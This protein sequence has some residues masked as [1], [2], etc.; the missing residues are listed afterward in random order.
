MNRAFSVLATSRD[1]P[2]DHWQ[3]HNY[4]YVNDTSLSCLS[5]FTSTSTSQ[6]YT[7]SFSLSLSLSISLS[8]HPHVCQYW[9]CRPSLGQRIKVGV[10]SYTAGQVIG[11]SAYVLQT[12][13][14]VKGPALSAGAFMGVILCVGTLI[15]SH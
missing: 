4:G 6:N 7:L 12:G 15:R 10:F 11:T 1:D 3:D 9:F 14:F 13:R 2:Y 8:P 5:R